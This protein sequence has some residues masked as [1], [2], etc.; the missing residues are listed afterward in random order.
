MNPRTWHSHVYRVVGGAL[1]A[2]SMGVTG[3]ARFCIR[4]ITL[5]VSFCTY[6]ISSAPPRL[7]VPPFLLSV[8]FLFSDR[9]TCEET[10]RSGSSVGLNAIRF[11]Y[12]LG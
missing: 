3:D 11:E 7:S 5:R 4:K 1:R 8:L 10:L 12:H 6:Y 9:F 2:I